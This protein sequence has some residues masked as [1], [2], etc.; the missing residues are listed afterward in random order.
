M[1][2]RVWVVERYYRNGVW[3]RSQVPELD[4][5]NSNYYRAHDLK[6]AHQ[7]YASRWSTWW[8]KN[9]FRV[10]EYARLESVEAK[11]TAPNTPST[12]R[13]A[14]PKLPKRQLRTR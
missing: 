11:A 6:R 2:E 7:Q 3:T 13:K 8:T 10:C 5:C 4:S 12:A 9:H 14:R 1:S